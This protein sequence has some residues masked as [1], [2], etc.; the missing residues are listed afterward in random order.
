M[1]IYRLSD[2]GKKKFTIKTATIFFIKCL[3]FGLFLF[4]ITQN[5]IGDKIQVGILI[6]IGIGII[7]YI[8]F[9]GIVFS[10]SFAL[11]RSQTRYIITDKDIQEMT[12]DNKVI[13]LVKRFS[14][15]ILFKSGD[16]LL[17]DKKN[18]RKMLIPM[19]VE[20]REVLIETL[21]TDMD[22]QRIGILKGYYLEI[23]EILGPLLSGTYLLFWSQSL[24][25][26]IIGIS[27]VILNII[28]FLISIQY[29]NSIS[30]KLDEG[31]RY[32]LLSGIVILNLAAPY[33]I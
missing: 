14:K 16:L 10:Y 22:V 27:G 7:F 19:E 29:R 32:F 5:R 17:L 25:L 31:F 23:I 18:R 28:Y 21:S 8:I 6:F 12:V 9:F 24:L 1:E 20:K 26:S 13:R 30:N 11:K 2:K 3:V 4:L 33:F 15:A